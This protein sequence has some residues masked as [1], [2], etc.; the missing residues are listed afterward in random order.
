MDCFET[1]VLIL[2]IV[3]GLASGGSAGEP[4]PATIAASETLPGADQGY[5]LIDSLPRDADVYFDGKFLGETPVTVAVS[6]TGKPTHEISIIRGGYEPWS[7][8]YQGNPRPGQ[9][10]TV[11]ATLIHA[12]TSGAIQVTSLPSGAVSTLDRAQTLETPCT[13]AIVPIGDHEVSVY[14]PGYQ[15]YYTS[16]N[17]QKGE[18]AHV[19]AE[20][21]PTRA[22]GT[23]SVSS[24]PEQ[25]AV[26]IDG[27]YRGVT[28]LVAGNLAPGQHSVKV[29][30]SGYHD[31]TGD[32][33]VVAGVE[34][35]IR[36][37]LVTDPEPLYGTVSI[38]SSPPGADVYADG[39]YVGQTRI[40]S[41]LVYR[42]VQPGLHELHLSMAGYQDYTATG[43]VRP[44]EN[45]D[46]AISLTPDTQAA[47]GIISLVSLPSGADVFLNNAHR[48]PTPVTMHSLMP[49]SYDVLVR[50]PG[51]QDWEAEVRVAAAETV[52]MN[53]TL[54]PRPPGD[55]AQGAIPVFLAIGG[56]AIAALLCF[57]RK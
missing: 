35:A 6:I 20:L 19:S 2:G 28:P 21:S 47:K 46:L 32:V 44:G 30:K 39:V 33:E 4:L 27:V 13:Y 3:V 24:T 45:Y 52:E 29:S 48:G 54:I 57:S 51:Y 53:A 18:T 1:C 17:V 11:M 22:G 14:F 43:V 10:A 55:K 56:L 25:A 36:P 31:W 50:L 26:H 8:A 12:T 49:G 9:T 7:T 40:G 16:V 23:L 41:P 37:T 38:M 5:F 15:T 42:G 34:A